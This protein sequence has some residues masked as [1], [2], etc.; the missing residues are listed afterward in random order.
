[1]KLLTRVFLLSVLIVSPVLA[2]QWRVV[3]PV[4]AM[5]P[6]A[7]AVAIGD[8]VYVLSGTVGQGL[9]QFF[10]VYDPRDD[11]WRPL[12]PL[13]ANIDRFGVGALNGRI[14]VTG[15]RE[16]QTGEAVADAW[17]YVHESALW[18][19]VTPL[20]EAVYGHSVVEYDGALYLIGGEGKNNFWR[21]DRQ[22]QDWTV[23][24][25]LPVTTHG[26]VATSDADYIYLISG[27][28]AWQ[29]SPAAGWKQMPRLPEAVVNAG[30]AV[31][32]DGLHVVGGYNETIKSASAKHYVFQSGRWKSLP[33]LPQ[34]RHLMGTAV[35]N[36]RLYIIGGASA[37]GF[38]S[39]FTGSDN[40][41]VFQD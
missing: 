30:I 4:P 22:L 23:L 29:W 1:M 39:F 18:V 27:A 2:G 36:D 21:L 24:P 17:L 20:P 9:R 15:G 6:S 7:S 16:R 35:L 12:T 19:E 41:Y 31:M 32:H 25:P 11:G 13:P 40:L 28:M 26:A 3:A 14:I 10:E 38:F 5:L 37:G 33:N 34:A 8:Q